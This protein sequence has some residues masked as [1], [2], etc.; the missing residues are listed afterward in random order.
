M[1]ES[2]LFDV[3]VRT[4]SDRTIE[5]R[6]VPYD[7][8]TPIG[9]KY[10]ESIAPPCFDQSL[11]E[12]AKKIPLMPLHDRSKYGIGKI[13]EWEH[14]DDGL[15]MQWQIADTE[16]AEEIYRQAKDGFVSGLSVGFVPVDNDLE[17]VHEDPPRIRRMKARLQEVSVVP[18]GAYE[19]ATITL[20][21]TAGVGPDPRID[22]A[23]RWLQTVRH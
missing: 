8:W 6:A 11:R 3:Q 19:D 12:R 22:A 4:G 9:G 16:Q 20:V 15:H 2:R 13:L 21:R 23:R 1:I 5:G 17:R 14:R 10:L 7:V 18:V